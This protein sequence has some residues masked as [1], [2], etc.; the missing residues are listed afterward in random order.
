MAWYYIKCD[1]D[2]VVKVL[3]SGRARGQLLGA[4]ARHNWY[5]SALADIDVQCVHAMGNSN[6][7]ADLL[8]RWTGSWLDSWELKNLMGTSTFGTNFAG[9]L[10]YRQ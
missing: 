10:R 6:R 5:L 9:P 8:S 3:K 7:I 4:F 1:N 2:A